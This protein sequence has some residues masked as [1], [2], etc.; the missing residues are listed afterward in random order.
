VTF[1]RGRIRIRLNLGDATWRPEGEEE[2]LFAT[3][4]DVSGNPL[5]LPPDSALV[6]RTIE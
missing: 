6:S 3:S 4:D 2:A 1:V 5:M